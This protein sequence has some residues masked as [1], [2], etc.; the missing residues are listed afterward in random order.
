MMPRCIWLVE[1]FFI[2]KFLNFLGLRRALRIVS[3][4]KGQLLEGWCHLHTVALSYC[5]ICIMSVYLSYCRSTRRS[6]ARV[7]VPDLWDLRIKLINRFAYLFVWN[8]FVNISFSARSCRNAKT[9]SWRL[10][11]YAQIGAAETQVCFLCLIDWWIKSYRG[12]RNNDPSIPNYF[13]GN[14]GVAQHGYAGSILYFISSKVQISGGAPPQQF[15]MPPPQ[16][17]GQ[18]GFAG[19][20]QP[21][22]QPPR[23][24]SFWGTVAVYQ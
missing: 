7:K 12:P 17:H 5:S 6:R 23:Y 2:Y 22:E 21:Y 3:W 10:S 19:V 14:Q 24:G 18:H 20:H 16:M 8:L 15:G 9:S 11:N 13:G 4:C 1:M